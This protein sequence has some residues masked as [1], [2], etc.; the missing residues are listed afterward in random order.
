MFVWMKLRLPRGLEDSFELMEQGALQNRVLALPGGAFF[1]NGAKIS[2]VRISFSLIAEDQM[3]D[4]C[5]RLAD[6]VRWAWKTA[7]E[8]EAAI[9]GSE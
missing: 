3:D 4:A 6:L 5:A 1:V 2:H 7:G 9:D 8:D